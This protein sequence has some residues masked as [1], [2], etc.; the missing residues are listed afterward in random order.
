MSDSEDGE[1]NSPQ[2]ARP[3][4]PG[5]NSP[6][7]SFAGTGAEDVVEALTLISL[8]P[9]SLKAIKDNCCVLNAENEKSLISQNGVR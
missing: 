5:N 3:A 1:L 2:E 6:G 8:S 7:N 9:G 4:G